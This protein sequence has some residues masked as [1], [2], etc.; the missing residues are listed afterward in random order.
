MKKYTV[1]LIG[2]VVVAISILTILNNRSDTTI[3]L[4]SPNM[5]DRESFVKVMADGLEYPTGIVILP[6]ERIVLTEQIGKTLILNSNGSLLN[7]LEFPDNYFEEGA[8]LLGITADPQFTDNHLLYLFYT[9]K[10]N[11][12]SKIFNKIIRVQEKNNTFDDTQTLMDQM[13]ASKLHNGGAIK[14]GPDG[15]LYVSV[16]DTTNSNLAQNLSSLA[17]KILRLNAN[18]TIPI[19][20]PFEN[21]PIYSYGHR[22]VVGIAWDF[23]NNTMY[24]S[25]AGRIGNDEIN[26]IKA[27]ENYG[28]PIEECGN[29]E[30]SLF[31][32]AEFCFTPSIYPAGMIISN[33]TEL[34]YYG[35]LLVATLKGEHLRSIDLVTKDQSAILTGYGKIKDVAEDK[36][37]SLYFITNNRDFFEDS[38]SD[39]LLKIMRN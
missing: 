32:N 19:D 4:P 28:W 10:D 5:A 12:D 7:T 27:G 35:K 33:S 26:I 20:N 37:G 39:R 8:G 25:E 11:N 3:L 1:V 38:G 14:F 15:K 34:N 2:I 16:G 24:A 6:D 30:E 9:Y 18:G 22:N 13:P 21:S 36:N 17:G 29:L 31:A 23:N